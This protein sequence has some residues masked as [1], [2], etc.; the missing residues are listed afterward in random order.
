[1][2]EKSLYKEKVLVCLIFC[3][4]NSDAKVLPW[5]NETQI[6]RIVTMTGVNT[7]GFVYNLPKG[8]EN[9]M[10]SEVGGA[11]VHRYG[12]LRVREGENKGEFR[13]DGAL[14]DRKNPLKP[15]IPVNVTKKHGVT[16][17]STGR[18]QPWKSLHVQDPRACLPGAG[19]YA[20]VGRT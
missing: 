20:D 6:E 5:C 1:M 7:K 14:F 19:T 2:Q 15:I 13:P 10:V 9:E 17:S 11:Q 16:V 8:W 3:S 4:I 12:R 18:A